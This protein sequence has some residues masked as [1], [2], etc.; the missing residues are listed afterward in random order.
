MGHGQ[1][2]RRTAKLPE[3]RPKPSRKALA[4]HVHPERSAAGVLPQERR[5]DNAEPPE[6]GLDVIVDRH[7][8]EQGLRLAGHPPNAK[9]GR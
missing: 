5:E 7:R 9:A 1:R 3:V 8:T 2:R 4:A 6:V